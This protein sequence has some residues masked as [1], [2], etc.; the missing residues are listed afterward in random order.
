MGA[1]PNVH[2]ESNQFE[3]MPNLAGANKIAIGQHGCGV[4]E[5][6]NELKYWGD[7]SDGQLEIDPLTSVS[8]TPVATGITDVADVL[9]NT[10]GKK[11]RT[12]DLLP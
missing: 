4:F 9:I 12:F 11:N 8:Y 5:E 10:P 2:K 6:T 1:D 3:E 7:N